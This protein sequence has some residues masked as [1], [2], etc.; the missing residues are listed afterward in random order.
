MVFA[1]P[2]TFWLYPPAFIQAGLYLLDRFSAPTLILFP[3]RLVRY[4]FTYFQSK[5][6]LLTL[7]R[8]NSIHTKLPIPTPHFII[9]LP[10][11]LGPT[12]CLAMDLVRGITGDCFF[13]SHL[14]ERSSKTRAKLHK[15]QQRVLRS[16][17]D[18]QITL[19]QFQAPI[20]GCLRKS[21]CPGCECY[22]VD[23]FENRSIVDGFVVAG[24]PSDR[25][26]RGF[27]SSMIAERAKYLDTIDDEDLEEYTSSARKILDTIRE[28]LSICCNND[29][30]PRPRF[31]LT[32]VDLGP[33]NAIFDIRGSLQAVI[34][35]DMLQFVPIDYAVQPPPGL[36]LE[37]F[38]ASET[39]VWRAGDNESGGQRALIEQYG[40]CLSAAGHRLG[41]PNLGS[42][43]RAQLLKDPVPLIQGLQVVDEED[44]DYS[45]GWLGSEAVLRLTDQ[46]AR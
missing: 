12:A 44:T 31:Y 17:A 8:M 42:H 14:A 27:Y 38:A 23:G 35:V 7:I 15:V 32:N 22:E 43:F 19:A 6:Y 29:D 5:T 26:A 30:D 40:E 11:S 46:N 37:F 13:E 3:L 45:N 33:R 25:T 4:L 9:R 24:G 10:T 28:N 18:I 41:L 2:P 39:T 16:M 36:G 1:L 20:W 34:D 21:P